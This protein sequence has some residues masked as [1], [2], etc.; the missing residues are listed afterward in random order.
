MREVGRALQLK[1]VFVQRVE[2]VSLL[3]AAAKAR[4]A[5]RRA[6]DVGA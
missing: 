3:C 6:H 1:F 5:I 2:K 4:G